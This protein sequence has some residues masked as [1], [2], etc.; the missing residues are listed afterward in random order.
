[1]SALNA[2]DLVKSLLG[3]PPDLPA[4]PARPA[5]VNARRV[6][7]KKLVAHR[8]AG[9]HKFGTPDAAPPDYTHEFLSPIALFEGRNGAGKTSLLNAIIWALETPE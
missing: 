5:N 4:L 7:L 9:L 1:V 2:E 8:F 3:V 6:R